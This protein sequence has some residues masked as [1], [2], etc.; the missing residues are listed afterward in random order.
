[1]DDGGSFTE[2][3]VLHLRTRK[4]DEQHAQAECHQ[5]GR[6][7]SKPRATGDDGREHVHVRV[8]DRVARAAAVGEEPEADRDREDEQSE[9]KPGAL[10]TDHADLAHSACTWTSARTPASSASPRT[11]TATLRSPISADPE[12]LET[13][14]ALGGV[15]VWKAKA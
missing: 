4:P 14:L 5:P 7:V 13:R 6:D 11:R 10:E 15:R 3:R 2:D 12:T 9:Q 8:P 1:E